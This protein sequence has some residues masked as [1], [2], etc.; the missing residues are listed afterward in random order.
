MERYR[1][2]GENMAKVRNPL[3]SL[4]GGIVLTL[5]LVIAVP[6]IVSYF[7]EPVVVD[8]IGDTAIATLSSSTI[9]AIVM[10]LVMLA[11]MML[12]G[13]GAILR[14]FGVIGIVG[15]ILAYWLIL[16]DPYGAVM[17]IVMIILLG[18]LSYL[19][20]RKKDKKD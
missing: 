11:F 16:D 14:K 15:L 10:F 2:N 12:L 17:P 3:V 6:V 1:R 20:D 4:I 9:S 5:V 19:K 13:G 8:A 7:I 18:G